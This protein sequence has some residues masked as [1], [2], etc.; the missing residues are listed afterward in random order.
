MD[1][2]VGSINVSSRGM[3][4]TQP[5][6]SWRASQADLSVDRLND[7]LQASTTRRELLPGLSG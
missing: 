1:R 6:A 5:M 4:I 7:T 3:T 2:E